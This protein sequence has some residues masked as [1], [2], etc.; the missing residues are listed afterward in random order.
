MGIWLMVERG[1]EGTQWANAYMQGILEEA[2]RRERTIEQASLEALDGRPVLVLGTTSAWLKECLGA[3]A[4]RGVHAV[5]AGAPPRGARCSF[6][7]PDYEQACAEFGALSGANAQAKALLAVHPN[8][9]ADAMKQDAFSRQCPDGAVYENR[10]SLLE[11]AQAL[12]AGQPGIEAVLCAND[13]AAMVLRHLLPAG[14][15]KPVIFAFGDQPLPSEERV[16]VFPMRLAAAG[17][18]A[19]ALYRAAEKDGAE[20]IR[21]CSFVPCTLGGQQAADAAPACHPEAEQAG[22]FYSDPQVPEI[23]RFKALLAGCDALD[24]DILR[25]LLAGR[26]YFDMAERLHTT[27]NTIKYRL[28]RMM[29]LA[30]AASRSE[31]IILAGRSLSGGETKPEN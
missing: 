30:G 8:S 26:R 3:L 28:R 21:R 10:G 15:Q 31:L 27:E 24:L 25:E 6:A 20:A 13:V 23:L 7:A 14:A 2:K 17:R 1:Y 29:Q 19:V 5:L 9:A 22:S 11:S 4:R 12:I 16:A 18:Q